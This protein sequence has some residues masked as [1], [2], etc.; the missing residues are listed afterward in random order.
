M[1]YFVECINY[2][3]Y[4]TGICSNLPS[5]TNGMISYSFAGSD[6]VGTLAIYICDTGYTLNGGTTRTCGSD[7]V[8][9]GSPPV[10]Q[11]KFIE[12]IFIECIDSHTEVVTCS[13][14]T[15]TNGNIV[16]S[17]EPPNNRPI[18]TFA[19]HTCDTGHTLTGGITKR[20]CIDMGGVKWSGSALTCE[21]EFC[22]S[23]MGAFRCI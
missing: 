23:Y 4:S 21:S 13:D 12:W 9:S 8:W 22:N 10:C 14:L 7:G 16:Y 18:N 20:L 2:I 11:R 17:K 3:I 15:L 1:D 19:T 6:D 5:L